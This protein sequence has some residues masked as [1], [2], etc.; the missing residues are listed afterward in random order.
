VLPLKRT[1]VLFEKL[2]L[3]TDTVTWSKS[4]GGTYRVWRFILVAINLA[5]WCSVKFDVQTNGLISRYKRRSDTEE[6]QAVASAIQ[7]NIDDQLISVTPLP[8]G[9]P[10]EETDVMDMTLGIPTHALPPNVSYVLRLGDLPDGDT[11]DKYGR[12]A[13]AVRIIS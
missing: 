4:H 5:A 2:I 9:Y 8:V 6:S 11:L 12:T 13:F 3:I 1:S 7:S 10:D